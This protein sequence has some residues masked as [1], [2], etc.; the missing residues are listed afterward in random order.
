MRYLTLKDTETDSLDIII[1]AWLFNTASTACCIG[2]D[3]EREPLDQSANKQD[4]S[5]KS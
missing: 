5:W 4:Q 3:H 2:E 1:A